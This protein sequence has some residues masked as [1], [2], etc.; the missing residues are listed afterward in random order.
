M[1]PFD[2]RLLQY[3]RAT[4]GLLI[5]LGVLAFLQVGTAIAL[6]WL[7]ALIVTA[8]FEEGEILTDLIPAI[9]ALIDEWQ[10][11]CLVVGI[12]VHA[13]GTPHAM[14]AR[15]RRFARQLHGRH[16]VPVVE[17]DERYTTQGA[18][19]ALAATGRGGRRGRAARDAI[20]AQAILQGYF[21]EHGTR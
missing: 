17:A 1:R 9:A 7:I 6:A 13:D 4:R 10:P 14:T 15:A 8:V 18:Q 20:A 19:A 2:P 3:A 11:G 16:G 21:D 12:P 5:G